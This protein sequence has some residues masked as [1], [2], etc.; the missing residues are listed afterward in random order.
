MK[1]LISLFL[2]LVPLVASAQYL[3]T[4][5]YGDSRYYYSKVAPLDYTQAIT[6]RV[7][8]LFWG[9]GYLEVLSIFDNILLEPKGGTPVKPRSIITSINNKSCKG[10][11]VNEFYCIAD[12]TDVISL[13]FMDARLDK[14]NVAEEHEFIYAKKKN[15]FE[16]AV[17]YYK[18]NYQ[19]PTIRVFR[20]K[21]VDFSKYRTYD[22]IINDAREKDLV[23][24]IVNNIALGMLPL[25][26]DKE[27]PDIYI[28][29]SLDENRNVSSTYVPPTTTVETIGSTTTKTYNSYTNDYKEET[30]NNNRVTT[31]GGY[32]TTTITNALY[33][34]IA[35]LDARLMQDTKQKYAPVVWSLTY[36][37]V[38]YGNN[39]IFSVAPGIINTYCSQFPDI[40]NNNLAG[41]YMCGILYNG[42]GDIGYITPDSPAEKMGLNVVDKFLFI[43]Y[44]RSKYRYESWKEF[45][46]S[47]KI[48]KATCTVQRGT[49]T[50]EFLNT[51]LDD[52]NS[53]V[54]Y[55]EVPK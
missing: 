40:P 51:M 35:F 8:P 1:K 42:K 3:F 15:V 5:A 33:M 24:E 23:Q 37:G 41:I 43:K 16:H 17:R 26:R 2:F 9:N 48:N 36:K 50:I 28:Q 21:E 20:D 7:A 46:N 25:K 47:E 18:T 30:V 27:N 13:K 54:G 10:M 53:M 45:I 31:E 52:R 14:G 49:K 39:D 4:H 44:Y 55:F 12:T 32:T 29:I 22:Y 38:V 11:S 19:D 34:E 6:V